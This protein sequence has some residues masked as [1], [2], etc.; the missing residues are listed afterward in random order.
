LVRYKRMKTGRAIVAVHV[1]ASADGMLAECAAIRSE[2]RDGRR[3][4]RDEIQ[5]V[6]KL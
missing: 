5:V 1:Q 4:R 2:G 6:T 3:D